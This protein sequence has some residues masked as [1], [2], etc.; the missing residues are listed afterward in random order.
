M[1]ILSAALVPHA[2]VRGQV[3]IHKSLTVEDGLVQSQIMCMYEDQSG[4]LW[5]GTLGGL[6]RWDGVN[7]ENFKIKD[8]LSSLSI[9]SIEGG[10][11][12]ALYFGTNGGGV[13]VLRDG[14]FTVFDTGD[15]LVNN[16]V[17][18]ICEDYAGRIL[19]GTHNGIS[20][21][22]HG[23][24][25]STAEFSRLVGTRIS[26]I[27]RG[28]DSCL[29]IAVF[30]QGVFVLKSDLKKMVSVDEGLPSNLVRKLHSGH[31][32]RLYMSIQDK[33]VAIYDHGKLQFINADSSA[34]CLSGQPGCSVYRHF[35]R[36]HSCERWKAREAG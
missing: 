3:R 12:G 26:D 31:D 11:D 24:V 13:C 18:T 17:R 30:G 4:F 8:G 32:G 34:P 29:Y 2:T 27:V 1:F 25:D 5:L 21:L 33:G 10:S 19:L 23:A 14:K 36:C 20:V 15:G 35:V 28:P 6:S 22:S 7:F 9:I 16:R